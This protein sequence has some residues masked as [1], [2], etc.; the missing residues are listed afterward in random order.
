M[1]VRRRGGVSFH[2]LPSGS[3]GG[4]LLAAFCAVA[5][6]GAGA[7]NAPGNDEEVRALV[8]EAVERMDE[9]LRE[10]AGSYRALI[11]SESREFDGSGE[12]TEETRV[13]WE[14]IP[15]DG[16]RFSR[17]VAIDG[18]PLTDEEQAREAERE[19]AFRERLRRLRAGEIEPRRNENDIQFNEELVSRYDL[20]LAGEETLRGGRATG[21]LSRRATATFPSAGP[22]IARSTRRAAESGSIGRRAR[23]P[24]SSS[25]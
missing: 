25:S 18:R 10:V 7:G 23:W 3:R 9:A 22:W 1:P 17:R 15:L 11:A 24:A 14:S 21:S 6:T 4:L 5:A 2:R 16:A 19:A 12:V 20:T 8:V 13:E